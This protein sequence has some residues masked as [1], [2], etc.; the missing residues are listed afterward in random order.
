MRCRL[1]TAIVVCISATVSVRAELVERRDGALLVGQLLSN[2][3]DTVTIRTGP[4]DADAVEIARSQVK[5]VLSPAEEMSANLD[6]SSIET[7]ERRAHSYFKAGLGIDALV[8]LERVGALAGNRAN[9]RSSETDTE[10]SVFQAGAFIQLETRRITDAARLL[11]AAR[12]ANEAG[13]R[14]LCV[15]LIHRAADEPDGSAPARAAA[16][17]LGLPAPA[18]HRIDLTPCL[19][20]PAEARSISDENDEVAAQPDRIFVHV[21]VRIDPSVDLTISRGTLRGRDFRS[22]Y[23]LRPMR[24][25]DGH[26]SWRPGRGDPVYERMDYAAASGEMV[27]RNSSPPRRFDDSQPR[28][29]SGPREQRV[30]AASWVA[31]IFELRQGA[32]STTVQLPGES[33]EELDLTFIRRG[34]E[35]VP[36]WHDPLSPPHE[37]LVSIVERLERAGQA[38]ADKRDSLRATTLFALAKL[39]ATRVLLGDRVTREWRALTNQAVVNAIGCGDPV[40]SVAGWRYLS[41]TPA[42][43]LAD[44]AGVVATQASSHFDLA[45]AIELAGRDVGLKV[46]AA[47]V[48][49]AAVLTRGDARA[50]ARVLDTLERSN[51][52]LFWFSLSEGA[53]AAKKLMLARLKESKPADRHGRWAAAALIGGMDAELAVPIL[54][55]AR[56][57]GVAIE[58]ADDPILYRW[59]RLQKNAARASFLEGLSL[60]GSD[61]AG[62]WHS[63]AIS[64]MARDVY[65]TKN[66]RILAGWT[67]MVAAHRS[68]TPVASMGMFPMLVARESADPDLLGLN[69]VASHGDPEDRRSAINNLLSLGYVEEVQRALGPS[70]GKDWPVVLSTGI[71]KNDEL[72]VLGLLARWCSTGNEEVAAAAMVQLSRVLSEV[73]PDRSWQAAAAIKS[74][75]TLETLNDLS[76]R[77]DPLSSGAAL[78]VGYAAGHMTQQERQRVAGAADKPERLKEMHA[79]DLRRGQLVD[80]TYGVLAIVETTTRVNHSSG[81]AYW[82]E[83]V[84]TL[85][86]LPSLRL[87]VDLTDDKVTA[88]FN[89][90]S[91][92]KGRSIAADR[93]IKPL[94]FYYGVLEALDGDEFVVRAAGVTT[95]PAAAS[96]PSASRPAA[97]RA[98]PMV[99]PDTRARSGGPGLIDFDVGAFADEVSART[100]AAK[101]NFDW[102]KEFRLTLRYHLWGTWVGCG[103]RQELPATA[104]P[105]DTRLLNIMVIVEKTSP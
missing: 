91:I 63:P 38:P 74:G 51:D 105:G 103:R 80:G 19:Y 85:M 46:G 31:L 2:T 102:P 66:K 70:V 45:A 8:C 73:A 71:R 78:R 42:P 65:K 21:P 101:I 76:W 75:L 89:G 59:A 27:L 22:L 25:V 82:S 40:V 10:W 41:K 12:R 17:E 62:V 24:S 53:R 36:E 23:G 1:I 29:R 57:F 97:V 55:A 64:I 98:G 26:P 100:G 13:D 96:Q 86:E 104:Q 61:M 93:L 48:A 54:A 99:L 35:P 84:R 90:R 50:C 56:R 88:N 9:S 16:L 20:E 37:A 69:A 49:L 34:H 15:D 7:L 28:E 43:A 95:Q 83:P 60:A 94:P 3:S 11:S 52:R 32:V 72:A 79:V 44:L 30:K 92:G 33:A 77:V 5:K 39:D 4:G 81:V 58:S 6:E 18:A 67:A 87:E 68:A 47:S 14:R